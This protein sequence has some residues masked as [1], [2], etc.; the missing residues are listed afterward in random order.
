MVL[1][2]S[3]ME[4]LMPAWVIQGFAE[5]SLL[6]ADLAEVVA[7]VEAEEDLVIGK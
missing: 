1:E 5:A 7:A 2:Q 4:C 3:A 6:A